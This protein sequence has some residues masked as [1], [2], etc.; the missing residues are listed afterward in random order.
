MFS[1]DV[2]LYVRVKISLKNPI[3]FQEGHFPF[4]KVKVISLY[5]DFWNSVLQKME[6]YR[7]FIEEFY[8]HE[9]VFYVKSQH[10]DII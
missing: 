9:K 2:S 3:G 1:G 6:S 7:E 4:Y 8:T 5:L 10:R